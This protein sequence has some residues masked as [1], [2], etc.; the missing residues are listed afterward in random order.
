MRLLAWNCCMGL[1]AKLPRIAPMRASVLVLPECAGPRAKALAPLYATTTHA[2]AGRSAHKGLGVFAR[3]PY[4]LTA[5]EGLRPRGSLALAARVEGPRGLA[6]QLVAIW[7]QQPRRGG[8]TGHTLRIVKSLAPF[9]REAPTVVAGD[10][11]ACAFF[12][13]RFVPGFA[14]LVERL[15]ALGVESA[16]HAFTREAHGAESRS[17]YYHLRD[18]RQP[19]HI[20]FVFVPRAWRERLRRVEVGAFEH[21]RDASDHCPVLVDVAG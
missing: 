13:G 14:E 8:Y 17:T 6:F 1:H 7:T 21:W 19:Y 20:D 4:R 15:D 10:F 9:I 11:N 5:V 18:A 2:W 3:P 16:Y 12:H